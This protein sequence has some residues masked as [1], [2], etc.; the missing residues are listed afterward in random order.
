M[1]LCSH[2]GAEVSPGVNVACRDCG[3][4]PDVAT[5]PA[6]GPGAA[7]AGEEEAAFDV[8]ALPAGQR[9]AVSGSLRGESV[10]FRWEPGPVL[11][12]RAVDGSVVEGLLNDA[13]LD[14]ADPDDAD[15]GD[16]AWQEDTGAGDAA[17][18]GEAAQAAMS[19]LFDAASRL[20]HSPA[21][22]DV[23]DEVDRLGTTMG[24]SPPPYG[25]EPATWDQ[26][27]TMAGAV[28]DAAGA[29]DE[30]AVQEAARRVRE[31]LRDYV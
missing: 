25:I 13:D 5:A 18:A 15:L 23:V 30:Q 3:L 10:P 31:F 21:S 19:D 7:A 4:S 27:A 20:V 9:M 17:D 2:C 8:S 12:V 22:G 24:G 28:V 1:P 29:G 11:V 26:M 6:L 14:D 16:P